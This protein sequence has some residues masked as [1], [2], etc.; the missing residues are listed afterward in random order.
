[1]PDEFKKPNDFD[2]AK[3]VK[4][5]DQLSDEEKKDYLDQVHKIQKMKS[6]NKK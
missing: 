1:M 2:P 5:W 6:N 3:F 4:D